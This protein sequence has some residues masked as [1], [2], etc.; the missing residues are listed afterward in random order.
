MS[1]TWKTVLLAVVTAFVGGGTLGGLM[2][3]LVKSLIRTLIA[4][5]RTLV[6]NALEN[7]RANTGA[8]E[9]NTHA[10]QALAGTLSQAI[11][12]RD[13][14]DRAMFKQLDRIEKG[15]K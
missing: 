9:A 7:M 12:V 3:W 6:D 4:Q 13:E 10:T 11:A 14:R 15:M 2:V 1:E 5:N 8:I